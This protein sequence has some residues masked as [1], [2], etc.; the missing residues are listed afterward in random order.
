[1]AKA[2]KKTEKETAETKAPKIAITPPNMQRLTFRVRG[3][4]P[5]VQNKM[6]A[7]TAQELEDRQKEG[8][9][10]TKK[11]KGPKDFKATYEAAK[12]ISHEGWL[13]VPAPAFRSACIDACRLVGFEMTKAK[14]SIFIEPDGLDSEDNTPLVRITKG[15]PEI[16]KAIVRIK[17]TTDVRWRPMWKKW[18]L[19]L[20]I[21]FDGDQ[22]SAQDVANLV[23]RAGQQIGIGE[24]RPYSKKS[25]GMGWGM[26][27]IAEQMK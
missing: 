4:A 20:R 27:T 21:K 19:L 14:C 12:H 16:H 11:K 15:K 8:Q 2:K 3:I 6:S 10:K 22:F 23:E 9:K 13:G 25:P 7:K 24:G 18:E 1:M 5:Y 17:E 26:F